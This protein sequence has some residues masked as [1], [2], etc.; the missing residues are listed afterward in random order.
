M[1]TESN[2]GSFD[3]LQRARDTQA[4][5]RRARFRKVGF[6]LA[7]VAFGVYRLTLTRSLMVLYGGSLIVEALSGRTIGQWALKAAE[8]LRHPHQLKRRYGEGTRD[9]VD[10]ASW[11]SFPASDPP[12]F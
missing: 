8:V 6:G 11:Q 9:L 2:P 12:A 10:E 4:R 5:E 1:S 3:L 7:W